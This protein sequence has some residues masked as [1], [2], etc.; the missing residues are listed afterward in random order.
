MKALQE[1]LC[2]QDNSEKSIN[3]AQTEEFIAQIDYSYHQYWLDIYMKSW[4]F[5]L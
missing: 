1:R 3:I 5:F 2:E 4:G